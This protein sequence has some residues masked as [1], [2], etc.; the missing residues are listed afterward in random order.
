MPT[1]AEQKERLYERLEIGSVAVIGVLESGLDTQNKRH[2]ILICT[3][4]RRTDMGHR[5]LKH[6]RR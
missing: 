1:S 4:S 6:R 3:N 2:E 5:R